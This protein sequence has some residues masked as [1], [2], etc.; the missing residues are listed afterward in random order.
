MPSTPTPEDDSPVSEHDRAAPQELSLIS[1]RIIR[2]TG[3]DVIVF[4]PEDATEQE[5]LSSFIV[6]NARDAID[7]DTMR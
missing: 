2:T 1:E 3:D 4:Y 6:A 5:K 7:C